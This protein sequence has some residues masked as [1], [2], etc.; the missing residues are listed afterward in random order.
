[1]PIHNKEKKKLKAALARTGS[2][3]SMT[4]RRPSAPAA[5]PAAPGVGMAKVKVGK[6]KSK[7]A[8]GKTRSSKAGLLFP[9]GRIKRKIRENLVNTRVGAGSAVYMAATLEYL[10]A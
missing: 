3:D 7:M 6:A 10:T 2:L 8:T 1:M 9:V 4:G 5:L